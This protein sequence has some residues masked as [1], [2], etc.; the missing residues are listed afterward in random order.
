MNTTAGVCK[1]MRL[2][3]GY[4]LLVGAGWLRLASCGKRNEK[5]WR[6]VNTIYFCC[7][8]KNNKN[9]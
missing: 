2:L 5:N 8:L 3:Y 9:R 6:T 4:P 7:N 1:G